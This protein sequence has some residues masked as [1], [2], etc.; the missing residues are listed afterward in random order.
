MFIASCPSTQ[1]SSSLDLHTQMLSLINSVWDVYIDNCIQPL[2]S[3]LTVR[4]PLCLFHF[5]GVFRLTTL[6][7]LQP[8]SPYVCDLTLQNLRY[9]R[10]TASFTFI[11]KTADSSLPVDAR[12]LPIWS[13]WLRTIIMSEFTQLN[14]YDSTV[15]Y[16][17]IEYTIHVRP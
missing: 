7:Q 14:H 16:I 15:Y 5:L 17:Q 6:R 12:L 9:L 2:A 4:A 10:N 11:W 8:T 1:L 13:R 3:M